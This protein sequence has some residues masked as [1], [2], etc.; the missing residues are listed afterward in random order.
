MSF[1]Q[2]PKLEIEESPFLRYTSCRMLF[3]LANLNLAK[4]NLL[5]KLGKS[6][7]YKKENMKPVDEH[8]KEMQVLQT[9]VSTQS[10]FLHLCFCLYSG[11]V[12]LPTQK[13]KDPIPSC[14]GN[15]SICK[16]LF[17]EATSP[18]PAERGMR[19]CRP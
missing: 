17:L 6:Y 5:F 14:S 13:Q 2:I 18:L 8:Q 4:L 7:T 10:G 11:T 19:S 16:V 15:R 3:K 9:P 1:I 12:I